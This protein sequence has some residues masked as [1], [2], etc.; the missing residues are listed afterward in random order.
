ML[1][2][3]ACFSPD[4]RK[5]ACALQINQRRQMQRVDGLVIPV[6]RS[7]AGGTWFDIA[8]DCGESAA[9]VESY[10]SRRFCIWSNIGFTIVS[11]QS[12]QIEWVKLASVCS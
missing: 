2:A 12:G 7:C 5:Q 1:S 10:P 3:E 6:Q 9:E 11:R 4:R 8:A